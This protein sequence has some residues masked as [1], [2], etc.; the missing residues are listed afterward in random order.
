MDQ[1]DREAL[2]A[3]TF[4][5]SLADCELRQHGVADPK[6]YSGPALLSQESDKSLGRRP[7]PLKTEATIDRWKERRERGRCSNCSGDTP[8]PGNDPLSPRD[9]ER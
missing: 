6:I 2:L 1:Q 8:S 7:L 4:E 5:M 9:K 3:G